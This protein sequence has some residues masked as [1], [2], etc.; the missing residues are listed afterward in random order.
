MNINDVRVDLPSG[1]ML[2]NIFNRQKELMEKYHVIEKSNGLLITEDVPVDIHSRFG[3]YRIK[4]FFWRF[5]EELGEALDCV[6]LKN[7]DHFHEELAD[8]LHFL[9]EA[10][11]L[12]GITPRDISGDGSYDKLEYLFSNA[13]VVNT[14]DINFYRIAIQ[15]TRVM[16]KLSMSANCLKNKPWKQTHMLTDEPEFKSMVCRTFH[17]F[18]ILCKFCGITIPR[19]LYSLYFKKSEVNKFRQRSVY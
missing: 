14:E 9:V 10:C 2:E 13:P 6:D 19:Y 5:T 15:F 3:Q 17:E 8:A 16:T 4:D 11:I 7:Q 12:I 1:D 18:I